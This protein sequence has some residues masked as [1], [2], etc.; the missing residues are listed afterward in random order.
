MEA[1]ESE[2]IDAVMLATDFGERSAAAERFALEMA[3][4]RGA[5]LHIVNAIE[6]IMGVDESDD[7]AEEFEQ[8]YE[9]LLKRADREVEKRISK[10]QSHNIIVRHHVQIGQRWRVVLDY[11]ES[12]NVDVLVLG[13]RSYR[14]G[15][16][17]SFGTTSQ[18]VFFGSSRPVLF[19]PSDD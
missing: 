9:K 17:M 19:V 11:A 8:F 6:P 16:K 1:P 12:A 2:T 10:W 4:A 7:E 14:A 18:K 15:E 3:V 13:R 5:A